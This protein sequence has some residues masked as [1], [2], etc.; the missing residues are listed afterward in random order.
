MWILFSERPQLCLPPRVRIL[1]RCLFIDFAN[2]FLTLFPHNVSNIG[3]LWGECYSRVVLFLNDIINILSNFGGR[4]T[5]CFLLSA[6]RRV[7]HLGWPSL[8]WSFGGQGRP[9]GW[10]DW[11]F[12]LLD[13][14]STFS[15]SFLRELYYLEFCEESMS[16][17][18]FF[19]AFDGVYSPILADD[20]APALF[21]RVL[22]CPPPRV[23]SGSVCSCERSISFLTLFPH[24]TL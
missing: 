19:R 23:R 17:R 10:E 9:N 3:I 7:R 21:G 16:I 13:A 5:G 11:R 1:P 4:Y 12:V 24:R 20:L 22:L 15:P 6:W 18:M 14:V 2:S 8:R